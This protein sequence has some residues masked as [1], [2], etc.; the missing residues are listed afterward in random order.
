MVILVLEIPPA[1]IDCVTEAVVLGCNP[2]IETAEFT[3][4]LP[5]YVRTSPLDG[6]VIVT[7]VSPPRPLETLVAVAAFPLMSIAYD[8]VNLAEGTVPAFKLSAFL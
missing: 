7:P 4:A 1:A 5:V 6:D 2:V 3:Q 8:H